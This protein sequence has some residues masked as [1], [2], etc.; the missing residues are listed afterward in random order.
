MNLTNDQAH[1]L[2]REGAELLQRGQAREARLFVDWYCTAQ[3]LYV[4]AA[5]FVSAWE[6]ALSP[7]LPRQRP[8]GGGRAAPGGEH[9]GRHPLPLRFGGGEAP[10]RSS[11]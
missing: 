3:S 9:Q 11:T 2:L 4:D 10:F 1:A 5:G 7:L 8:P 6:Q